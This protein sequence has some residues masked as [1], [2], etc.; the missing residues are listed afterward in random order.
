[1]FSKSKI[2]RQWYRDL[3]IDEIEHVGIVFIGR[4]FRITEEIPKE[5]R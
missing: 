2:S 1:M 5:N 3:A 4:D